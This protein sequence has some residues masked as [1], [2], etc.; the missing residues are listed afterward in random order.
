[1]VIHSDM[2]VHVSRGDILLIGEPLERFST[3]RKRS[4]KSGRC[5]CTVADFFCHPSILLSLL[6]CWHV[7]DQ[8]SPQKLYIPSMLM[9]WEWVF[10]ALVYFDLSTLL[11]QNWKFYNLLVNLPK[12]RSLK[13]SSVF[14]VLGIYNFTH[15]QP[16]LLSFVHDELVHSANSKELF[17]CLKKDNL[18]V[19]FQIFYYK[20][21]NLQK[22]V[23]L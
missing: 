19:E 6:F 9:L 17:A 21:D 11:S 16:R 23:N 8:F 15:H 14:I 1:M 12:N 18:I 20:S 22:S 3:K 13:S 5:Y 7:V 10:C 2:M 4:L